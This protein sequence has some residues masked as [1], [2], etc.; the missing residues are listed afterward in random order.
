MSFI[1]YDG[2]DIHKN[3]NKRL[4]RSLKEF[5]IM[6]INLNNAKP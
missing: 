6:N 3:T 5:F 2:P 4:C 1:D